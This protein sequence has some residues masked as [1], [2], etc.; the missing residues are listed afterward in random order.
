[1]IKLD[2]T[3]TIIVITSLIP[4]LVMWWW[5]FYTMKRNEGIIAT[6]QNV[7]QCPFC[8]YLFFKSQQKQFTKCPRCQSL[9]DGGEA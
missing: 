8:T 1:M 3:L 4:V 2:F 7:E 9:L 5:I 6:S